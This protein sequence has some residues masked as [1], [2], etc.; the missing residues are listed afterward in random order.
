MLF[1]SRSAGYTDADIG[2][3]VHRSGLDGLLERNPY[4]LSGGQ[5][6][7]LALAKLT[8]TQ[9]DLLLLDEPTKGLDPQT[10]LQV[11]REIVQ[12]AG[13]GVTVVLA[14]HDLAFVSRV[15]DTVTLL[16][17]GEVAATQPTDAFFSDEPFLRPRHDRF[18]DLWDESVRNRS[19]DAD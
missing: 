2:A 5:Q 3:A 7:A 8:L 6:Q 9:P 12:L 1:R 14:T 10:R 17:D 11:G 15:A 13:Q 19:A 4:D 18:C 16:F